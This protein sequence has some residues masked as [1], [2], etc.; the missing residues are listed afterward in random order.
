MDTA[1]A[2]AG[3]VARDP[4][5]GGARGEEVVAVHARAAGGEAA[6]VAAEA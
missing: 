6:E 3:A 2:V 5:R 1:Q 4:P